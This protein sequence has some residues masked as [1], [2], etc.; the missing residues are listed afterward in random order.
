MGKPGFPGSSG[1]PGPEGTIGPIGKPA[2]AQGF[3]LVRHSQSKSIPECPNGW[4][5]LWDGYS[6]LYVQGHD[7]SHGQDLGKSGSCMK[8]FT[9][10][11]YLFCNI[12][13]QCHYASRNDYS[14]WLTTDTQIPM[15]PISA[16]AV[17]PFVSRCSVCEAPGP[18]IA[19]HSQS[20][21]IP[22]CPAGWAELWTGYSFVM[23]TI[24]FS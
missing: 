6:L 1:S 24:R 9:T 21:D 10:M 11:P 8:R 12:F 2:V 15:M 3:H 14:Y 22:P 13:E 4:A 20:T 19:K 17:E 23:V 7:H 5:K 18:V 16:P